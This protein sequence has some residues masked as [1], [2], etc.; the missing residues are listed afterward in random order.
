MRATKP[1]EE[2]AP[3]S[4]RQRLS[5]AA[6][7]SAAPSVGGSA[8]NLAA[9]TASQ[10]QDE[11]EVASASSP[12]PSALPATF[13]A[14]LVAVDDRGQGW[15]RW[16]DEA[17]ATAA[18]PTPNARTQPA[19]STIALAPEHVGREV[20]ACRAGSS[21][22]AV[23]VG[24]LIGPADTEPLADPSVDLVVERRR[25]VFTANTELVLRCGDGSITLGADGKVS[26]R[27]MDVVSSATRTQRIRGGAVRI[28]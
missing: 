18:T 1:K 11:V 2:G 23:I 9:P 6:T 27:G 26:I 28:N 22:R 16:S 21:E 25:I 4:Q 24:V 17:L 8:S 19:R 10:P 14:V 12:S 3:R 13:T 15:I 20:L 7:A 5:L